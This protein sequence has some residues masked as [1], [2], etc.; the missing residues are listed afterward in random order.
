MDQNAAIDLLKQEYS[1]SERDQRKPAGV[2]LALDSRV[3]LHDD[4]V[5]A[6]AAVGAGRLSRGGLDRAGEA[7]ERVVVVCRG[8]RGGGVRDEGVRRGDGHCLGG[9]RVDRRVVGR[10]ASGHLEDGRLVRR[11]GCLGRGRDGGQDHAG[12][13]DGGLDADG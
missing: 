4:A 5:H 6:L 7:H 10:R 2:H 1:A 11:R 8:R 12:A 9:V 13:G 3:G